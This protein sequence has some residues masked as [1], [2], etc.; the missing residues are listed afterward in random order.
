MEVFGQERAQFLTVPRPTPEEAFASRQEVFELFVILIVQ[1]LLLEKLPQSFDQIQV[2]RI[3]RQI[4]QLDLRALQLPLQP[5]RN[6]IA[7]VVHED[8][9]HLRF[10]MLRFDFSKQPQ[11]R[12]T[13][14]RLREV[15]HGFHCVDVDSPID[16]HSLATAVRLQ[17]LVRAATCISTTR[18]P[19]AGMPLCCG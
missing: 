13:V 16:I 17:F 8:M 10:R 9:N 11:R 12:F 1:N 6:V 15:R 19:Y 7:R 18:Q 14:D 3:A 5:F 4:M 2:R